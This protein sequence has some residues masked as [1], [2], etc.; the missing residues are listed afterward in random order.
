MVQKVIIVFCLLLLSQVHSQDLAT[1]DSLKQVI[2]QQQR[3]QNAREL[4]LSDS[5]AVKTLNALSR[6]YR[7]FEPDQCTLHASKA[8]ALAKKI[9]YL[10]GQA[11]SHCLLG[12]VQNNKGNFNLGIGHFQQ[13][14]ALCRRIPHQLL[15]ADSQLLLGQSY[16]YLNNFP[17]ALKSIQAALSG[18]EKLGKT[19]HICRALNNLG[20]LYMK[21]DKHEE[22]LRI[23]SKALAILKTKP[24]TEESELLAN[25]INGNVAHVYS[26][27]HKPRQALEILL[28]CLPVDLKFNRLNSAG[29]HYQ[30]IGTNYLELGENQK[31]FDALTK[32]LDLF[33]K[34]NNK[35][36]QGDAFR[37]LG[38]FYAK[39]NNLA[40]AIDYTKKGLALSTQIGELESIKFGYENLSNLYAKSGKF[41]SAYESHV[42]YKKY[43]DSILNS[44]TS[45]K[46]I[47]L[48]LTNEFEKKE[49]AIK[50]EQARKDALRN[51]AERK[52]KKIKYIVLTSMFLLSLLTIGI[53]RNLKNHQKQRRIIQKQ[54]ELIEASLTEKETLLREIHHRVKNNLQIIS[55]LLNMQAEEISDPA[56]LASIQEGQ[57]RVQ[58]MSLIHQNLYQSEQI[59]KVDVEN[60]LKELVDYLSEMFGGGDKNTI[61]TIETLDIRFDFD[62]AIPLGLIVNELVSNAFKYGLEPKSKGSIT[63]SICAMSNTDYELKVTNKGKG[64]PA[65]FDTANLKTLGLKLVSILSKQL[66]GGFSAE[67]VGTQTTFTVWF[68]DI[69]AHNTAM[70]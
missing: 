47:Q 25:T 63:I 8:L 68:K 49:A 64:L 4:T 22:V 69:K 23:Y 38:Q 17:E 11:F 56:V 39:T 65:D 21:Q 33:D 16:L 27:Q 62:T 58:A 70:D 36:G 18:Y 1:I 51:I 5:V 52:E 30:A 50:K 42:A 35:S 26:E 20:I 31:A 7:D 41:D 37:Y 9:N 43:S 29:L 14:I 66:R 55:S 15:L 32:A 59:N 13:S 60:Y 10:H 54:K 19:I 57:S 2:S 24:K 61:V 48:Q 45:K 12:N 40:A 44:E 28:R 46:L 6:A 34:M 3:Q 67:T 53:Y